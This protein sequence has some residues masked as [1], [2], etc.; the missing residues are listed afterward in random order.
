MLR[1]NLQLKICFGLVVMVVA[2]FLVINPAWAADIFF[3]T[4]QV[5]PRVAQPFEVSVL[6]N[7]NNEDINALEGKIA[8]PSDILDVGEIKDGNSLVNFWLEKPKINSDGRIVFSGITPGGYRDAQGWIFSVIFLPKKE[9][10]GAISLEQARVLLNDGQGTEAGLTLSPL[11]FSIF[12]AVTGSSVGLPIVKDYTLPEAF[13]PQVSRDSAIFN[14]QWFLVFATQ[15]KGSGIDH[16]EVR[17]GYKP[18]MTVVS[19]YLL[20]NQK[21]DKKITVRAFDR[22]G[23]QRTVTLAAPQPKKAYENYLNYAIILIVLGLG[24]F[25]GRGVWQK[26]KRSRKSRKK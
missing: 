15:D 5:E 8:F 13:L 19:P 22:N 3:K 20:I 14:G 11:L 24:Y 26:S 17:E 4:F 16:Y 7:T 18:F 12:P 6:V 23:N 25:L 9:G 2:L 1:L 10:N 21:L